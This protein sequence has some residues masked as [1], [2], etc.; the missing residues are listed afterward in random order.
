LGPVRGWEGCPGLGR[1]HAAPCRIPLADI[2]QQQH[3]SAPWRRTSLVS[4]ANALVRRICSRSAA[5]RPMGRRAHGGPSRMSTPRP[6]SARQRA[7]IDIGERSP[8]RTPYYSRF[9]LLGGG[10]MGNLAIG[11]DRQY[12]V[13]PMCQGVS[14][15]PSQIECLGH[16]TRPALM[17][18]GSPTVADLKSRRGGAGA[19]PGSRV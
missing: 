16:P 2:A 17:H 19:P 12:G 7:R 1:P 6:I 13:A 11:R 9:I 8:V 3:P 5:P 10:S 14:N 15:F 4:I 18:T